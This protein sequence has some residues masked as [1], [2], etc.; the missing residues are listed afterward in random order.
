MTQTSKHLWQMPSLSAYG[1]GF[2][3][4]LQQRDIFI[5]NEHRGFWREQRRRFLGRGLSSGQW[6]CLTLR[7]YGLSLGIHEEAS[8][9]ARF[10]GMR[11]YW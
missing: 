9:Y 8:S 6:N 4:A 7:A 11:V 1:R 10:E 5:I 2:V 3:S